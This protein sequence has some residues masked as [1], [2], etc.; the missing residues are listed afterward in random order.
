[1]RKTGFVFEEIP[2]NSAF[3]IEVPSKLLS[4]NALLDFLGNGLHF[5]DYF[6]GNWDA[7]EE[8]IRDLSWL[9]E[10]NI[11]IRHLDLPLEN[12]PPSARIYLSILNDVIGKFK[13]NSLHNLIV[14]FPT[15]YMEKIEM[16]IFD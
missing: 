8:C 9:K 14:A 7:F 16:L 2:I 1:M 11:V 10:H 4:K 5:P 6:G 13:A 3:S 15:Q 12:E